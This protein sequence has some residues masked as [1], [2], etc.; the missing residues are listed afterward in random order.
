MPL[1]RNGFTVAD[2]DILP[3]VDGLA[4]QFGCRLLDAERM[5]PSASAFAGGASFI[6]PIAFFK[7]AHVNSPDDNR[8]TR[9]N[10]FR[11]VDEIA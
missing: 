4:F 8:L 3:A 6:L 2:D 9:L 11:R 1:A 7:E 5:R 10:C